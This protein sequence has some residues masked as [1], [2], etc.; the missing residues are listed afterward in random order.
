MVVPVTVPTLS[1]KLLT[2]VSSLYYFLFLAITLWMPTKAGMIIT[3]K[4]NFNSVVTST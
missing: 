4:K 2:G 1:L 3:G